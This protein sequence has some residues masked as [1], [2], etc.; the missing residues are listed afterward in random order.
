[1]NRRSA[2]KAAVLAAL[3]VV[4]AGLA[5]CAKPPREAIDAVSSGVAALGADVDTQTYAPDALRDAQDRSAALQ[6]EV[7][8]QEKK[9]AIFRRYEQTSALAEEAQQAIEDAKAATAA[10]KEQVRVEA[11]QAIEA[12]SAIVPTTAAKA[13]TARRLRGSRLDSASVNRSLAAAQLMLDQSRAD[14]EAGS[15]ASARAKANA[16]QGILLGRGR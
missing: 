2:G 3:T 1:M 12:A 8:S 4:L 10:G 7:A 13:F 9:P 5:G 6:A 11:E 15:Y 16:A 14:L